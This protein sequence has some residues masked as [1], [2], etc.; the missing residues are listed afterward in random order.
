MPRE[1]DIYGAEE[2]EPMREIPGDKRYERPPETEPE[3]LPTEPEMEPDK[4]NRPLR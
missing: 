1:K 2:H 3:P 4:V